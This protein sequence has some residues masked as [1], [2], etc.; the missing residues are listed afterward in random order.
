M[1]TVAVIGARSRS[2]ADGI[3]DYSQRLVEQLGRCD[4]VT[5]QL[6][7]REQAAFATALTP[8][9]PEVVSSC[10]SVDAVIV[11]YNPFWYGR[12]G[13]APGLPIGLLRLRRSAPRTTIALMVH[14]TYIWP[15]NWKWALMSVWQRAQLAVMQRLSDVQLCSIEVWT[16]TLQRTAPRVPAHHLPVP[17]NLPD[18]RASRGTAR[19]RLG[20]PEGALVLVTF[21][22]RHP[23]R[24][25]D[26]MLDAARAVA[27]SNRDTVLL[28]LGTGEPA[29]RPLPGGGRLIAPGFLDGDTAAETLAA[30]DIFMAAFADGVSTRRGTVMAALQHGLPVVGT[31]GHLTDQVLCEAAPEALCLTPVAEPVQFVEAVVSLAADDNRRNALGRAGRE[32]YARRFDW[33]V[34]VESLLTS[35]ATSRR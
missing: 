2:T 7:Q 27:A 25:T 5:A 32:L 6:F 31:C 35:L 23:G 4:G 14:E 29:D 30:G 3:R 17:S 9:T 15:K 20:I 33:P 26:R 10:T 28:N 8:A 16:D 22:L 12:R 24:L 21:G 11:Q 13:F 19:A 1:R 34:M 18:R